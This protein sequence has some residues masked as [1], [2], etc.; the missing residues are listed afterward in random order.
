VPRITKKIVESLRP[1][2]GRELY[3]ADDDVPGF[4]IR[5]R[6]S[7]AASYV[8]RYRTEAG[9]SR[10]FTLGRVAVLSPEEARRMAKTRLAAVAA[11]ADPVHERRKNRHTR[12]AT[13]QGAQ[14]M[15]Q[16]ER[17]RQFKIFSELDP[18]DLSAVADIAQ[19]RELSAGMQIIAE[20]TPAEQ[21]YLVARGRVAVKVREAGG[22]QVQI[23][24]LN[25][26]EV[27]GWG[28]V[29]EPHVYTASAWATES[30]EL[31]LIDGAALRRLC[32]AN[33]QLGYVVFKN[34]GEVMSTR[35]GQAVRGRG[36]DEMHRF[37]IFRDLDFGELDAIGRISQVRE[38]SKGD[39]LT[40]EGALAE[41]LYLFL[42]GSAEVRVRDPEGRQV[43]IDQIGA[44]DVL[45]WSA[46]MQP[47]IYT[48]S[49]WAAEPSKV[50][51][52]NG[53]L[54]R[55]LCAC[56]QHLG[57]QVTK[58]IGEVISRRFG[59]AV[60]VRG[61]LRAKDVRAFDGPE[62]VVWD[63]GELQLTTEAVLIGM[64]TDSPDVIPLEA[65]QG[66]DVMDGQVVFRMARGD[67]W[68]PELRDPE[69]LAA[70]TRDAMA[71]TRYAQR[72]KDYYLS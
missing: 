27:L 34:I 35:L 38:V 15:E 18:G 36:I 4:G 45:G 5:L 14:D 55:D 23:D 47:H 61:D 71:R 43:L 28:A 13:T 50:I 60:G 39:L 21:L 12:N 3:V 8:I 11:G 20:G 33:K 1:D 62:R 56:N 25:P 65:L 68:S 70:L 69:Q 22:G 30:A 26:G 52:V 40:T 46:A 24:E 32:D 17:I 53:P 7:G 66:V 49:A 48:A 9:V 29:V 58:G 6:P 57:Y 10:R 51:V 72:R 42:S 31:I 37:K 63:N 19:V 41:E 44:G 64:A 67:V 16:V 59:R 2:P 54:L